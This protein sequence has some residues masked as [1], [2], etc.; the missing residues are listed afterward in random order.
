MFSSHLSQ[1]LIALAAASSVCA[2]P[3]QFVTNYEVW[4]AFYPVAC[5]ATVAPATGSFVEGTCTNLDGF[6]FKFTPSGPEDVTCTAQFFNATGCG[7][8]SDTVNLQSNEESSCLVPTFAE[9]AIISQL[10]NDH[11]ARSVKVNCV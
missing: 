7:G 9:G 4:D 11:H 5:P 2:G 6:S 10:P 3:I 1:L 8:T